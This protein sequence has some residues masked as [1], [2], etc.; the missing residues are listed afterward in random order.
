MLS[1]NQC[2]QGK[3]LCMNLKKLLLSHR[4]D[5]L[6]IQHAS[7]DMPFSLS[8]RREAKI[9]AVSSLFVTAFIYQYYML[10]FGLF[11]GQEYLIDI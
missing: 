2:D 10:I 8:D 7:A 3:F 9:T 4:L 1:N 11:P 5:S 6:L